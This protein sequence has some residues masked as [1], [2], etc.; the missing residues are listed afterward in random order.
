MIDIQKVQS[1]L[2]REKLDGWLLYDFRGQNTIAIDVLQVPEA[3]LTR[4]W[5]YFIP[6]PVWRASRNL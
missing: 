6:A 3:I 2:A 4:R 5:F 1:A